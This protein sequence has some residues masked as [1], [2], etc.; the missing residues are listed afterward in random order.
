MK[1][2]TVTRFRRLRDLTS[3]NEQEYKRRVLDLEKEL[4]LTADL[5]GKSGLLC[6]S[7]IQRS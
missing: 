6:T 1:V 7:R 2:A 4:D 5:Q 3:L